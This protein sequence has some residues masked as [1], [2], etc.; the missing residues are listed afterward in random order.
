VTLGLAVWKA[1]IQASIAEPCDDAPEPFRVPASATAAEVS[2]A[3]EVVSSTAASF[4]AQPDSA[5][6]LT[7]ASAAICVIFLMGYSLICLFVLTQKKH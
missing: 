3:A 5:S 7:P 6:A 1:A 4:A 2:V